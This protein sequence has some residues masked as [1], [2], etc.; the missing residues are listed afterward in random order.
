MNKLEELKISLIE[1]VNKRMA[2][3]I[4]EPTN[5]ALL[6]KL[7]NNADSETE[8][9]A[10]AE[11]GTTYRITGFHF[12]KRLEKIGS[13]IKYL[14]KNKDL[15]FISDKDALTHKLII[16]DNYDALLNLMISYKG[17]VDVIYIDP[18]Y[19]S[20]SMGEFAETNYRNAITRDNLLSMLY[21]RLVLAKS[22][23][24]E[25]GIICCSIDDKNQ[26]YIK[27]LMDEI[28]GESNFIANCPRKSAG[29][30]T[31]KS[32]HEL[33]IIHDY[34]LVYRH[35]ENEFLTQRVKGEKK[36]PFE[37]ERG[38]YYTVPLQDNGPHGTRSQ[39]P[40]LWYPLYQ[41]ED[42]TV[43]LE[44]TDKVFYPKMHKH[45][46]GCWMWSK[47]KVLAEGNDLTIENGEVKIKHYY[48]EGEDTNKYEAFSSWI[49]KYQNSN[50]TKML[51]SILGVK[52]FDNPKP[53]DLVKY[54]INLC[55][56]KNALILDFFAG[57][58]TTGQ[59]VLEL[60][61]EDGGN[62]QFILCTN[63]EI[64]D[65]NPNGIAYDVTSK[66]LKRI[67]TGC[68][69]DNS[70]DFEWIKK[71]E[72]F[73]D[74]LEVTDIKLVNNAENREEKSAF[75]VIDETLYDLSQFTSIEEKINWVCNN[76]EKT[77]KYLKEE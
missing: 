16:G 17:E 10:I 35:S 38:K 74:N 3:K 58:G 12:D 48:V 19:G 13:D 7:I 15:S 34:V 68:C 6:I 71:N 57:S 45:E 65:M 66:R 50:G 75:E 20:D 21:P 51:N 8:A 62:R 40:N 14:A 69:Y 76:F 4:I 5:A 55:S 29:A 56:N 46:E 27:C 67:M 42:G 22:L 31:T 23:L 47:R 54:L 41:R 37:D 28:F 49:D 2:D 36:Y 52:T 72:A 73:G 53:V 33:Q 77:Q 70:N 64:T 61:R 26:A 1:D 25:D 30:R 60:N 44:E 59:A 18:P 24:A 9:L 32:K 63:N 43:T 39:R 11:L